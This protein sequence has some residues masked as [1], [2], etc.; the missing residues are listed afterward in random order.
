MLTISL[1][2]GIGSEIN[3]LSRHYEVK[4]VLCAVTI[5]IVTAIT[6]HSMNYNLLKND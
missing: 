1:R 6:K 4:L 2:L 3:D 5:E